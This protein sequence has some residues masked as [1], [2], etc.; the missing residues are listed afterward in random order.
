MISPFNPW[1]L[2]G[3][4]VALLAAFGSGFK[5]SK[6]YA[7]AE[8][9]S[10]QV[11]AERTAVSQAAAETTRRESIGASR[12]ASRKNIHVV[13]RTIREQANTVQVVD[14]GNDVT[15]CGL[16]ADGLRIWNAA[17]SGVP[18]TLSSESDSRLPSTAASTLGGT[19][20]F[21]GQPH[22]GDGAVRPMPGPIEQAS[23]VRE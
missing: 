17:N 11:Q 12:E 8:C 7:E 22:R 20:G 19:E 14:G 9:T 18:A 1:V 16:D 6:H 15:S 3:L 21:A 4:L 10:G 13:Y 23:G 5:V 2:L